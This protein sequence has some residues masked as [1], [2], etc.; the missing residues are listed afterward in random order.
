[1]L[2]IYYIVTNVVNY[3]F[4]LK[5]SGIKEQLDPIFVDKFNIFFF[6]AECKQTQL[7]NK[8]LSQKIK[9]KKERKKKTVTTIN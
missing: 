6:F 4:T 2:N 5:A 8:S 3:R 7:T 1:M 9:K